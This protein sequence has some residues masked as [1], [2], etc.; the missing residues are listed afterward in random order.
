RS[1]SGSPAAPPVGGGAS[2]SSVRSSASSDRTSP[3]SPSSP[4]QAPRSAASRSPSGRSRTARNSSLTRAW[5]AAAVMALG[6]GALAAQPAARVV[7]EDAA[8]ELRRHREEMGPPLPVDAL[9]VDEVHPR[10]VHQRR[11]LQGVLGALA[12]HHRGGA[13]AQVVVHDGQQRLDRRP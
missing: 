10:L 4:A 8:H 12:A 9:L 2:T 6:S 13:A 5:R 7:D 3:S 11:G 1:G